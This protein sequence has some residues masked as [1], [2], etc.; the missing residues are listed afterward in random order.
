M[1]VHFP[2]ALWPAHWGF[3]VASRWLPPGLAGPAGFWLLLAGTAVGWLAAVCGLADAVTFRAKADSARLGRALWH[4]GVNGGV[5]L[6]FS[7]LLGLEWPRYPEI[8]HGP[9]SLA[10][11]ALL[12]A[13]MLAGNYLGG[14][15]DW[16]KS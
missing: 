4:G 7:V 12:L 13:A 6:G 3:H 2:V 14:G 8:S 10:G 9:A 16:R 15:I 1:L 5:L 11:E